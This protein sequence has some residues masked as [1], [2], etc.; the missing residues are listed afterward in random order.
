MTAKCDAHAIDIACASLESYQPLAG[1]G[2]VA[3]AEAAGRWYARGK[4]VFFWKNG[5]PV[6]INTQQR[7]S[8]GRRAL[9]GDEEAKAV[10][11]GAEAFRLRH[12]DRSEPGAELSAQALIESIGI[13]PARRRQLKNADRNRAIVLA[14]LEVT[15]LGYRPTRNVATRGGA[16]SA[17]SIVVEALQVLWNR[18]ESRGSV[19]WSKAGG[20]RPP[21]AEDA[22][23]KV[24]KTSGL[25]SH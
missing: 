25:T 19:Q 10:W 20:G 3:V 22:V 14:V 21:M 24:W 18:P 5:R 11:L 6:G 2:D 4:D 7:E 1:G 23:E 9:D 15:G 17:C 12:F 16:H 13:D 8:W